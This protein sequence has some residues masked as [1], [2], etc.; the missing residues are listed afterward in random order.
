[1]GNPTG[2]DTPLQTKSPMQESRLILH[3]EPALTVRDG[4]IHAPDDGR[5]SR[6][7]EAYISVRLCRCMEHLTFFVFQWAGALASMSV[8]RN[9][10]FL[11]S[12]LNTIASLAPPLPQDLDGHCAPTISQGVLVDGTNAIM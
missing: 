11:W 3:V 6:I 9:T 12:F 5:V 10:T 7:K 1:M 4:G 8:C 2:G